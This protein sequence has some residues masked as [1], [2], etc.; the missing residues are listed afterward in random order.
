MQR[1]PHFPHLVW[2]DAPSPVDA[3]GETVKKDGS[4]GDD[5]GS[6]QTQ[7]G[8]KLN[9]CLFPRILSIQ[10]GHQNGNWDIYNMTVQSFLPR[11]VLYERLNKINFWLTRICASLKGCQRRGAHGL[12]TLSWYETVKNSSIN[13]ANNEDFSALGI[14]V[15]KNLRCGSFHLL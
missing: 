4:E 5:R 13:P 9:V 2:S 7:E 10:G 14:Q 3:A 12:S 8:K 11:I 6:G 15:E 1:Q